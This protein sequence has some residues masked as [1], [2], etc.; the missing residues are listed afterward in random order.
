MEGYGLEMGGGEDAVPE[1]EGEGE[2]GV[3]GYV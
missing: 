2:G 1:G 3:V